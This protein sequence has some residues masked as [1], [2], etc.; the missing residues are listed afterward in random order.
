MVVARKQ[1][2]E[3]KMLGQDDIM[4]EVLKRI[5][6]DGIILDFNYK[7]LLFSTLNILKTSE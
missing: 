3:G 1:V 2:K 5:N 4:P 7:V 6:I